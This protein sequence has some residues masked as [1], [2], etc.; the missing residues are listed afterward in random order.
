MRTQPTPLGAVWSG[1]AAGLVGTAAMTSVQELS[2]RLQAS[3]ASEDPGRVEQGDGDKQQVAQDP[4]EHASMP[5]QVARR[6]IEGVFHGEVSPE[7]IPMLTHGMHW[8]YGTAWGAV[9]GPI[10]ATFPGRPLRRGLLFGTGVWVMAYVQLVPMGLYELP[11][12]YSAKDL[13]TELGFHL[14]YGAGVGF[15]YR[16]LGGP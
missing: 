11:W 7:L 10:Q 15:G 12:R 16:L 14:A 13:A 5:A 1:L 4:W 9:Y 8:A 2:A 6:I 3:Q